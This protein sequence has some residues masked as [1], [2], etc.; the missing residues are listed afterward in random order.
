[1]KLIKVTKFY[2]VQCDKCSRWLST[3][4]GVG[5]GYSTEMARR[6]AKDVGFIVDKNTEKTLCPYC[7]KE[8]AAND[9]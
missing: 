9:R 5:M 8:A 3:D 7:K 2:D 6:W 4:F 1:M